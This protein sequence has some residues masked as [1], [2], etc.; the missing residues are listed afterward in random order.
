M[1]YHKLIKNLTDI[2]PRYAEKEIQAAKVIEN[3]LSSFKISFVTQPFSSE[4][5]VCTKAELKANG[6]K[7]E[8]LSSTIISGEIPNGDYLISH[9]G[10]SGKTPYNIAYSPVT[11]NI[12]VVDHYKVPSVSISRRDVIKIIMAKDIK[13]VVEI[14][15]TRIN[16]EN[17]LVGNVENPNNIVFAHF[18]SIVG[19]GAVDNAGSV[20][21]MMSC[22]INNR[23]LLTTTLFN[24]SGNEEIAYDDYK[25][26][27]YGFRV[28]EQKYSNLLKTAKKIIVMDGLGVGEPSFTQNGLDWVLQVK[29]LNQIRKKAFWL[30]NDQTPVLQYFHTLNDNDEIIKDEFLL[31]AENKLKQEL[32]IKLSS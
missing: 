26:S 12:S 20:A 17:I 24:F 10:Y 13:G 21:I 30:Q 31:A 27:G 15:R 18:D 4:V 8:C 28:F 22:L 19:R 23:D 3:L 5:L 2:G 9:F 14:K 32:A 25:L 29:M 7:I 11:D 1:D 16:T 6:K